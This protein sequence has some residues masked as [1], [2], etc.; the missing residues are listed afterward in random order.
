MVPR[1]TTVCNHLIRG[2]CVS[3]L[4]RLEAESVDMVVVG[5]GQQRQRRADTAR[6]FCGD[7]SIKDAVTL[8]R[9]YPETS[10]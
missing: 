6:R 7:C 1:S 4:R 5:E 8:R 10:C 9:P 2:D 3:G